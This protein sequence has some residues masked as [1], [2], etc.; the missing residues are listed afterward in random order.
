MV[1]ALTKIT[2][3]NGLVNIKPWK[4]LQ[5]GDQD[6][7]AKKLRIH[8]FFQLFHQQHCGRAIFNI[9]FMNIEIIGGGP[10]MEMRKISAIRRPYCIN[11]AHISL[12]IKELAWL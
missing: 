9:L 12:E 11:A 10:A 7:Q 6:G 2:N 5:K 8:S 4:V 3:K 1:T